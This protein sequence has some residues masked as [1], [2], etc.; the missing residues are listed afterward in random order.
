MIGLG[1]CGNKM[2]IRAAPTFWRLL[3]AYYDQSPV[4]LSRKILDRL[5]R[6][7]H[8]RYD[9]AFHGRQRS[10]LKGRVNFVSNQIIQGLSLANQGNFLPVN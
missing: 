5:R 10:V 9:N 7:K 1:T 3:I 2:R 6:W 8:G 4:T